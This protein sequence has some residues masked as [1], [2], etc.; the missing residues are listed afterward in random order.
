MGQGRFD[1]ALEDADR[2]LAIARQTNGAGSLFEGYA[3]QDRGIALEALGRHREA[4]VAL[5]KG[6]PLVAAGEN[7]SAIGLVDGLQAAAQAHIELGEAAI[8][9]PILERALAI[10]DKHCGPV[11][12]KPFVQFTLARALTALHQTPERARELATTA[13]DVLAQPSWRPW[14]LAR[15]DA[16][17]AE[18]AH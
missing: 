9:M 4:L 10:L 12:L 13:R 3:S 14:Q 15:V 6:N 18:H 2:M 17:L 5:D 16:W 8:A 11:G 1:D 7:A